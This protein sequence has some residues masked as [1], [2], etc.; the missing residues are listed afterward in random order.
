MNRNK[1][2]IFICLSLLATK[3]RSQSN[4]VGAQKLISGQYIYA[5]LAQVFEDIGNQ[6]QVPFFYQKNWIETLKVDISFDQTPLTEALQ[7]CLKVLV[8]RMVN[9]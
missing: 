5:P 3:V 4:Q 2:F 1:V 8:W 9:R 6:A 7:L